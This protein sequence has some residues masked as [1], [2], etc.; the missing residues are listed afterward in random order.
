MTT[1]QLAGTAPRMSRQTPITISSESD[2]PVAVTITSASES[3]QTISSER[4]PDVALVSEILSVPE[5][6]DDQRSDTIQ[7]V[8]SESDDLEVLEAE[9]ETARARREEREA[10][11]RL[12]KA[13]R[14]RGSNSSARSVHSV[15]SSISS[16]R[17]DARNAP[18]QPI[19][20]QPAQPI[21]MQPAQPVAIPS[22]QPSPTLPVQSAPADPPVLPAMPAPELPTAQSGWLE[23]FAKHAPQRAGPLTHAETQMLSD[24]GVDVQSSE[25]PAFVAPYVSVRNRVA[26]LE[27]ERIR[28]AA[29]PGSDQGKGVSRFLDERDWEL[30]STKARVLELESMIRRQGSRASFESVVSADPATPPGLPAVHPPSRP[31]SATELRDPLHDWYESPVHVPM[32]DPRLQTH[33]LTPEPEGVRMQHDPAHVIAVPP[34]PPPGGDDPEESSSS[35]SEDDA[36]KRK[37]KKRKGP[38]TVKNGM[39]N[40]PAYPN[41]LTFQSWRRNVRTA[42]ISACEKPERARAFMFSVEAE[43]ASFDS[44]AVSDTDRHRALDAKLADA[45][46]KVVKGDLSRRLAVM[47]ESLA[48]HGR[49]LAGRQILHLIYKEFGKDVHQTDCMSYSHLEKMQGPKDIKGLETFLAVWDNLMLNFQTPPKPD[50]MYSAFLSKIRI[51]PELQEPLKK[52]NRLPWND[53][54]KTY[55]T[56]RE[57]CDFLIE[58]TR[59]EKQNKQIDHLY[60]TGSIATALAATPEERAKLPCF[61]LRD[62][63]PCPNGK[64]CQYSHQKDVIELAKKAKEAKGKG[65]G[66]KGKG[67]G[68]GDKGK[69]KG[70]GKVCPFFND[71]GCHYGSACKMLHEAPAMAAKT[72][73]TPA[74]KAKAKAAAAL[75]AAVAETSKP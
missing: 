38:Y 72:D 2:S 66:D 5:E 41:A 61:Y 1:S 19:P 12:A 74:P 23:W 50:H 3:V 26:E 18:A 56:L 54:K 32:N 30:Q 71:K 11:E 15:R 10:L 6:E 60:D 53:P 68:K 58:E 55:E 63:K 62:G 33:V 22:V 59:Q 29:G 25:F 34:T 9:A 64:S 7:H 42:A 36:R 20:M 4:N 51:I 28:E 17:F 13:R 37:K 48:K 69:G 57:E 27:R 49:V 73:Q 24:A 8:D 67:K 65:K 70:K 75:K 35:S 14:A 45:L 46:L 39:M 47:S 31:M 16:A 40:L 21:S 52:L 43:D 44:L